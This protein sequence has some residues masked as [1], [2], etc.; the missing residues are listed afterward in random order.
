MRE[1]VRA[2][3]RA[4]QWVGADWQ[5]HRRCHPATLC[6]AWRRRPGQ[7]GVASVSRSGAETSTGEDGWR[8]RAPKEGCW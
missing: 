8:R 6:P 4:V 2:A 3:L 7:G 1:P 5:G